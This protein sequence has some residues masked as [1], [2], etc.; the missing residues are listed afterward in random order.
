MDKMMKSSLICLL[1]KASKTK[2]WLWHRHLS[3]LNFGTITQLAKQGLVKGGSIN[4]KRYILVIVIDHSWFTWVKFLRTKDEALEIMIEFLQ[5]AQTIENIYRRSWDYPSHKSVSRT[6]QQNGEVMKG[7]TVVGR[8]YKEPC[9]LFSTNPPLFLWAE[10]VATTY[11][12]FK[13]PSAV[14]TIIFA[15]TLT[16]P[17]TARASSSTTID[18]DVPSP[19]TSPKKTPIQSTIVEELNEEEEAKSKLD[20]D[21]NGTP[22][23]PTCYRSMVGF[24]MYLT[25]SRPDL[26]FLV[27]ICA[28]YQ[29]KPTEKHLTMVKRVFGYLKGT[30]NIGLWYSKDTEFD[31]T[32]FADTDHAGC[33]DSRKSTSGSVK[34]LGEKLVSWSF[35]KQKCT[36]IYTTEAEYV[37]LS[38]CCA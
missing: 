11:E 33:Q 34:F 35:K 16:P 8:G 10:A 28:R 31:L 27:C 38:D 26:A 25:T 1:S 7:I 15:A 32:A 14:S 3:H 19:S 36:T 29:G 6:P 18:Q 5:Q 17:D 21:P 37:S 9:F 4:E 13:S 22:V 12:Y 20:K 23:D 30:I 24:L 2:S